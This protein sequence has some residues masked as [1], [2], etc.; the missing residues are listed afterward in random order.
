MIRRIASDGVKVSKRRPKT[1]AANKLYRAV[2]YL[3]KVGQ[4]ARPYVSPTRSMPSARAPWHPEPAI[5]LRDATY[6]SCS[7]TLYRFSVNLKGGVVQSFFPPFFVA[8]LE[9]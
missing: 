2:T 3:C 1:A 7:L 8:G 4:Y 5:D 6:A 9:P